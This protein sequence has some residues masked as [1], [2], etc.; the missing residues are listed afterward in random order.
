[1]MQGPLFVA[2]VEDDFP[3]TLNGLDI[4]S[5]HPLSSNFSKSIN[6]FLNDWKSMRREWTATR[7]DFTSNSIGSVVSIPYTKENGVAW[8]VTLKVVQ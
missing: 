7:N 4:M 2:F 1:M 6:I 3:F 8:V 5:C